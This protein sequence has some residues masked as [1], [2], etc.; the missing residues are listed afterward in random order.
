MIERKARELQKLSYSQNKRRKRDFCMQT[1]F[2][3]DIPK[4]SNSESEAF[5]QYN[6]WHVKKISFQNL[7]HC[8]FPIRNPTCSK[9][10][11]SKSKDL[12]FPI[13][14]LTCSK[15]FNS[16]SNALGFL[17]FRIWRVVSFNSN[18]DALY[19][20]SSKSDAL[21]S[22]KS[23]CDALFPFQ[24]KIWRVARFLF[25]IIISRKARKS[26]NI[27]FSRIRKNE[28]WSLCAKFSGIRDAET[29]QIQNLVRF[30]H[31]NVQYLSCKEFLSK[32][33]ALYFS[34]SKSKL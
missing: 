2:K 10:P 33:N 21:F 34:N 25:K 9:S 13:P 6:I 18:S 8:N 1:S 27:S 28:A 29:S 30:F 5:F 7:M 14:N 23:N 3:S 19:L 4:I 20:L 11:N 22:F 15:S 16:N 17:K 32:S 12:F 31:Y 26:Q 24:F